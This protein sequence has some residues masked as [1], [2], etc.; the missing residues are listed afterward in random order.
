MSARY[1]YTKGV[2]YM[3]SGKGTLNAQDWQNILHSA[4]IWLAPLGVVYFGNIATLLQTQYHV[5]SF[6][7]LMPTP[8]MWGAMVHYVMNRL[9]DISRKVM[10]GR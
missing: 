10:D 1:L 3:Q 8:F 5:F 7:D 4:L 6:N 2:T 9:F